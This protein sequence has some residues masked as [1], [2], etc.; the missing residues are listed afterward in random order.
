[1]TKT[2]ISRWLALALLYTPL[3]VAQ[4][5]TRDTSWVPPT[6]YL[7]GD[8]LADAEIDRYSLSCS[9]NGGATFDFYTTDIQNTGGTTTFTTDSVFTPGNYRCFI[10]AWAQHP[11]GSVDLESDPSN[12]VVFIVGQCQAT[13][14]RPEAP[15]MLQMALVVRDHQIFFNVVASDPVNRAVRF[16]TKG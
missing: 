7:N 1:M 15:T 13:D 3:V 6:Q 4:T 16:S 14:C 10:T 2:T 8:A 12:Q 9:N 5:V 11:Q